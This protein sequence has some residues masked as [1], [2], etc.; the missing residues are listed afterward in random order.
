MAVSPKGLS[1]EKAAR[2]MV[3]LRGGGTLNKFGVKAPR[4]EAYFNA[5]R[6]YALEA[7]PLIEANAKAAQ[8]RKAAGRRSRTHCSRGHLFTLETTRYRKDQNDLRRECKICER[9]RALHGNTIKPGSAEQVRAL[10]KKN[11]R[12]SS[13]TAA[14]QGGYV[15]SHRTFKRLRQEDSE[16]DMLASSVIERAP[17]LRLIRY[18]N[19][20]TRDQNNDFYKVRAMLPPHFPDK[21]DVVSAMF[22]D[23]LTGKLKHEDIRARVQSYI[24]A[25]NRM[26]PTKY[27]K[28]GDAQMLSLDEVL[29]EDGATTRGD[30]VSQSLWD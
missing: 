4:L 24:T 8:L 7:R 12:I 29:F 15:M 21:D 27:A 26:F 13:F 20:I 30:N 17:H 23:L 1:D 22:E 28:F 6:E 2:M 5:H 11:A 18:R 10:L 19:Q 25:H 3:A 9:K 14:G 16:I